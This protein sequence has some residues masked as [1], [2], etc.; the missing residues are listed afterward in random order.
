MRSGIE[1]F[2]AGLGYTSWY[3]S[4]FYFVVCRVGV[5]IL[6][7]IFGPPGLVVGMIGNIS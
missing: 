5:A 7:G 6:G 3:G 1:V 2:I 4:K